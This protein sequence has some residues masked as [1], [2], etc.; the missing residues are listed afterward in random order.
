MSLNPED[1]KTLD[2]EV[3]SDKATVEVALEAHP[4]GCDIYDEEKKV[5]VPNPNYRKWHYNEVR[6]Y[7]KSEGHDVGKY[8]GGPLKLVTNGPN[9]RSSVMLFELKTNPTKPKTSK[10]EKP[11]P[12]TETKPKPRAKRQTP[13]KSAQK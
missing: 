8:L 4:N 5:F 10:N 12:V 2:I 7:L 13:K 11:E 1:F 6:S 3:S 9:R